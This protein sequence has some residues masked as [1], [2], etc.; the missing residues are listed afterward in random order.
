MELQSWQN[1]AGGAA[2]ALGWSRNGFWGMQE[3]G[4][5]QDG[6]TGCALPWDHMERGGDEGLE[7]Q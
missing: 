5:T 3:E 7:V 2:V 1:A 6:R 4:V